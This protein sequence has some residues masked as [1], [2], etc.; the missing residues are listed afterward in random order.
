MKRFS[1]LT[2]PVADKTV[3]LRVD[4][5]A[6]LQNGEIKDNTKIKASLSTIK[7]LLEK[8]CKIV[9]ATHL[10]R[11]GNN[12]HNYDAKYKVG[13]LVKELEQL[14]PKSSRGEIVS[15]NECIGNEVRQKVK[16]GKPRTIFFL[17]NLRFYKEEEKNDAFFAHS[18]ADLADV[19]VNDAFGVYHRKHA[20]IDAITKYLPSM[21]GFLVEKE[22]YNLSKALNPRKPSIWIIG[23]AK[24]NKID[25]LEQ[26]LKKADYILIGGALA[27]SF[28]KAKGIRVGMSKVDGKSVAMAKKIGKNKLAKKIILPVDFIAADSFSSKA[29]TEAVKYNELKSDQIGLDLG[30]ETIKLFKRYLLK[31]HTIVW[32]GPLGYYEW[33][34]FAAATKEVGRFLGKLTAISIC[35]G[36]ETVE[37]INNSYLQHN[38]THLSTG[39]GAALYFLS[40]KK[41][42]ALTA[43]EKSYKK[44]KKKI[45]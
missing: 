33:A 29:K 24:L 23:G 10:G 20:S 34:K 28:L 17:E 4:Y 44:F 38:I 14:L 39:G 1:L 6:P 35:G 41:F 30:P 25:L 18:L 40:G 19:Y 27:F 32:N 5:N 45:R 36:G 11:P 12:Q 13:P 16:E 31:A 15:L 22:L 21:P 9:L 8:N 43:M 7:F 2:F 3:F 37:A 42:P 26:A